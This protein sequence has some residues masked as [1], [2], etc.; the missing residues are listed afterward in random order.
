MT[1]DNNFLNRRRQQDYA[2]VVGA[3]LGKLPPQDIESEKAVI[4][5]AML[6][7][8]SADNTIPYLQADDFYKEAH[9]RIWFAMSEMYQKGESIDLLTVTIKL[10][11]KGE[12]EIC[13]G[14][15]YITQLNAYLSMTSHVNSYINSI[16]EASKK[17]KLILISSTVLQRV[18]DDMN[19]SEDIKSEILAAIEKMDD[20]KIGE[21][22]TIGEIAQ[23]T[24]R[25]IL[26]NDP[27]GIPVV[28]EPIRKLLVCYE[29]GSLICIAARPSVG[30]TAFVVNEL[31]ALAEMG[32]P[33]DFFS[34]EMT[35][36]GVM[37]R[38]ISK[39]TGIP[40]SRIRDKKSLTSQERQ[41][42]QDA[43]E[44]IKK[45]PL[46]IIDKG[47]SHING[48]ITKAKKAIRSGSRICAVDYLQLIEGGE[49]DTRNNQLDSITRRIKNTF[50]EAKVPVL[51]LSQLKRSDKKEM[52]QLDELR[53]SGAIE[54]HID[55]CMM[56]H[57]LWKV[58]ILKDDEGYST[59]FMLEAGIVKNRQGPLGTEELYFKKDTV[60]VLP[61]QPRVRHIQHAGL[62]PKEKKKGG[63]YDSEF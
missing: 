10:R 9:Q 61:P 2:S 28:L 16:L 4:C 6:E 42:I 63:F 35:A 34:I 23:E 38:L 29:F 26:S 22:K 5:A 44:C 47:I 17:R 46:R 48:L 36:E 14:G 41:Q 19:Q 62:F 25:N 55:V 40:L 11:S 32:I 54:Q 20:A 21:D 7:T 49:G 1:G 52:P 43:E 37:I 33:C 24:I 8:S 39:R 60:E 30:K 59:E 27:S 58:G 56:L 50:K 3:G 57:S 13:G 51:L 12:L 18:F 31:Y 15:Q 53:D 45:L